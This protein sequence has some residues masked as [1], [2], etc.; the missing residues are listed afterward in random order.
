[1]DRRKE[2]K[3]QRSYRTLHCD[4]CGKDYK[5]NAW[6]HH[7]YFRCVPGKS[8]AVSDSIVKPRVGL[9]VQWCA[10]CHRTVVIAGVM[11][12]G[13]KRLICELCA[14]AGLP[15]MRGH[16][17]PAFAVE[18]AEATGTQ[19]DEYVCAHEWRAWEIEEECAERSKQPEIAALAQQRSAWM[20]DAYKAFMAVRDEL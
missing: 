4:L 11:T 5:E 13:G 7:G 12:S 6:H 9:Q 14:A 19:L 3:P 15:G 1:M 20:L 2:R 10:E 18:W 8:A 16:D 17:L